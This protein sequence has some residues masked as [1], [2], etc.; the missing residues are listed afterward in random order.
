MKRRWWVV[1]LV[2]V[3]IAGLG[4]GAWR[5]I[6]GQQ[7][8]AA[9]VLSPA[10]T[11]VV[12]QDRLVAEAEGTGS[13][14]P[15]TE[16]SLAFLSG[17]TVAEILIGEGQ[18][19]E[20]GQPLIR[21]ET[22]DLELQV[23]RAEA[24]LAVSEGQLAQLLAPPRPE[25]V[26]A[27]EADLEAAEAQVSAAA[28]NRD[29]AV[30][31]PTQAQ[32][33]AAEAQVLAVKVQQEVAQD[34]YDRTDKKDKE[35]KE[36][37]NYDLYAANEALAAARAQLDVLMA[38]ADQHE[39]RAAQSNVESAEAQRDAAQA[40]LDALRAGPTEEQVHS[41]E[42]AVEQTRVTLEQ[43]RLQLREATLTASVGGTVT[44]LNV[45]L[46]EMAGPGQSVLVMSDLT[47]L[48]V[49]VSLDET[50][51]A[52]VAVGQEARVVLDAF[53]DVDMTGEVTTIAPKA[54]AAAGVVLYPVTVRL[55]PAEIPVRA[56]MTADV[57][58][59]TASRED[60]LIVPLRAVHVEDGRTYVERLDGDQIER[61]DV[62][63]GMTTDTEAE[64]TSGLAEGDVVVVV[65]APTG[66]ESPE[67]FGPGGRMF[68]GG[69]G[70]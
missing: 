21:L 44:A 14:A 58:I 65:A 30:A 25:E 67:G 9:E 53:P 4:I 64:I 1:P 56:G 40:Q 41:A 37:A 8:A 43:M 28:A 42:A 69:G 29:Q 20:A 63:L 68:G 48:E 51:V 19:V 23:A 55:T 60:T 59:T 3:V 24:G 11:A 57:A 6:S 18:A 39:V 7:E 47:A 17:G 34:A 5:F 15:T 35:R 12:R 49:D 70:H 62:G 31:G 61:V 22:D 26:A 36:Q 32:I 46:G 52:R 33:A 13:L 66:R 16:V 45:G 54:D 38:G 10:E 2:L 50:E 27:Q